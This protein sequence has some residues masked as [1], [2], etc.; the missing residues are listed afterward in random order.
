VTSDVPERFVSRVRRWFRGDRSAEVG[1]EEARRAILEHGFPEWRS[2]APAERDRLDFL[3]ERFVRSTNW[4]AA[5]GFELDLEMQVLI[6][7]QACLLLIGLELDEFPHAPTIIVHPSTVV[8]H[9]RRGIGV[10]GVEASGRYSVLGQAHYQGPV[11]L[12]WRAVKSGLRWPQH[13]HNVVMHEFAHKLDML[14]GIVDGTPPLD[15][16]AAHERWI[17]VCTAAYDG[18]REGDQPS[19]LRD[20]AGVN[21]GEF[22]AVATEVFFTRPVELRVEQPELYAELVGFYRQDPADRRRPDVPPA[23]S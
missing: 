4:E 9:G 15:D 17:E 1:T 16:P 10:G 22:F 11:L 14:D 18:V 2:L 6:A 5:R 21:P 8:L 3:V 13:G 19:V 12:S 20:Y 23:P 7:A